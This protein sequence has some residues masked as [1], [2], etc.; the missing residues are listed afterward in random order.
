MG[1]P[2]FVSIFYGGIFGSMLVFSIALLSTHTVFL[3]MV[4][5]RQDQLPPGLIQTQCTTVGQ[6]VFY[7]ATEEW[8]AVWTV[9]QPQAL[10]YN[11]GESS[12]FNVRSSEEAAKRDL[13]TWPLNITIPC[14]CSEKLCLFE[15]DIVEYLQ[16]EGARYGYANATLVGVGVVSLL[17]AIAGLSVLLWDTACCNAAKKKAGL[18]SE[19][20]TIEGEE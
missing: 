7:T 10:A 4:E 15:L 8:K 18:S 13:L 14:A 19:Y 6:R 11:A 12:P 9:M 1:L 20:Y 16:Q 2:R 5:Q 3:Q 17:A